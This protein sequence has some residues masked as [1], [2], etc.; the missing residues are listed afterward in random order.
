[1]DVVRRALS[2]GDASTGVS[3]GSGEDTVEGRCAIGVGFA[4]SGRV[5]VLSSWCRVL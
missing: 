4:V 1:V 2:Q 5:A 3:A